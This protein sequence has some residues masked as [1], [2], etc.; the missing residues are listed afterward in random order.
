MTDIDDWYDDDDYG[1]A[2]EEP[3]CP[4]CGDSGAIGYR[5]CRDCNPTWLQA[6]WWRLT[7]RFRWWPIRQWFRWPA[8]TDDGEA[9]F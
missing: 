1:P 4:P 9:P 3:H 6:L 8:V 2:Q 5:N 7:W